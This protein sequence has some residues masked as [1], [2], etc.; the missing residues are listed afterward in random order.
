MLD[1][2]LPTWCS[3]S[4][5]ADLAPPP[6]A[7]LTIPAKRG[8]TARIFVF[9]HAGSGAYPYRAL[10]AALPP[11]VELA[12]A[13]L[14]GREALFTQTPYR[15]MDALVDALLEVVSPHLDLPYVILGHSFGGHV[16]YAITLALLSKGRPSP[17]GL[18][19]SASRAPHLPL[20]RTPLHDLPRDR[21]IDELRRYGGTPEAV[22]RHD[23]LMDLFIPPLR[24]DL[25]I[26]ETNVFPLGATLDIPILGL[27][28][29]ADHSTKPEA[30]EA[31]REHTSREFRSRLFPGGH[32]YLFEESKS[33]FGDEL[34]QTLERLVGG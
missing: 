19:V 29:I 31:W 12:I 10:S 21:L 28:G 18:V 25:E 23:E 26:Y 5:M 2:A 16:A 32:F 3:C 7:L 13:Q 8:P 24:A 14:P 6:P 34:R 27:G 30:V 4:V 1:L 22:L 20:G 33:A 9:P 17:A 11:W 15:R